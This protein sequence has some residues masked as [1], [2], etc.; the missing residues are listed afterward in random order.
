MPDVSKIE[1][2][3]RGLENG[4]YHTLGLSLG[5]KKVTSPGLQIAKKGKKSILIFFL[6]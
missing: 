2:V 5:S 6:G 3:L 1:D 4:T